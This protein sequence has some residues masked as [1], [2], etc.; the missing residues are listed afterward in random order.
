[1]IWCMVGGGWGVGSERVVAVGADLV[2]WTH[3]DIH[4]DCPRRTRR[5]TF[6]TVRTDNVARLCQYNSG[7]WI[8]YEWTNAGET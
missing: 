1:M 4:V 7:R 8:K 2:T 3:S 5:L 6:S